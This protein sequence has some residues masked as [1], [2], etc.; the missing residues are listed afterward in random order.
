MKQDSERAALELRVA[1]WLY[2]EHRI[3]LPKLRE[4][5]ATRELYRALGR[6]A[7]DALYDLTDDESIKFAGYIE[8][9]LSQLG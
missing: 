1:A 5:A 2:L 7:A 9:R 4:D 3:G 8:D 6:A